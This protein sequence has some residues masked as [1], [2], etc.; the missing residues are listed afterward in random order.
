MEKLDPEIE[1]HVRNQHSE[2]FAEFVHQREA[3][4]RS[5]DQI[6]TL[7]EMD[8]IRS[9]LKWAVT[10]EKIP[11]IRKQIQSLWWLYQFQ[12]WSKEATAFFE[13]AASVFGTEPPIGEKGIVYGLFLSL[14]GASYVSTGQREEGVKCLQKSQEIL[15]QLDARLELAWANGVVAIFDM[16]LIYRDTE[17]QAFQESLS[18]YQ[19][20]GLRWG[21]A[22]TL[23]WWANRVQYSGRFEEAER[24]YR[25]ALQINTDLHDHRGMAW[26][27]GGFGMIAQ[28]QGEYKKAKKFLEE[29]YRIM[30]AI[31]NKIVVGNFLEG[32][33]DVS[34][35]MGEYE[36]AQ[37]HHLEALRVSRSIGHQVGIATSIADLG[38][39][40]LCM[41]DYAIARE[42]CQEALT[43]LQECDEQILVGYIFGIL[44]DIAIEVGDLQEAQ[45]MYHSA[46][47]IEVDS[48][49]IPLCMF[50][51]TAIAMLY[52]STGDPSVAVE[53]ATL[54]QSH[55]Q[56]GPMTLQ[57]AK[58]LFDELSAKL[59]PE[60]F[61][62]AQQRGRERD[63]KATAEEMLAFLEREDLVSNIGT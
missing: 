30:D 3:A 31:G 32:L 62:E 20:N 25:E 23:S 47:E 36:E 7:R 24:L 38:R 1:I 43:A 48:Q 42:R 53:L 37:A 9:G 12:G 18:I 61:R 57:R 50:I 45:A 26:C 35:Q 19:E 33:G 59:P 51:L 49:H 14:L 56:A 4:I 28:R 8:N 21:V 29:S 34:I 52:V 22:F 41:G 11:E 40:A 39:V 58:N 13:F 44:G 27:I 16:P 2:Y 60:I 63:V 10:Q 6:E 17:E 46:L 15:R 54:V 55:P 5:G